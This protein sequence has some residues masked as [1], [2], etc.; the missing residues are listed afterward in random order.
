MGETPRSV[1]TSDSSPFGAPVGVTVGAPAAR[2]EAPSVATGAPVGVTVGAPA[3]RDE[4]PSVATG[5][6]S[7]PRSVS[8]VATWPPPRSR[9][10]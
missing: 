1:V 8:A 3:A 10:A 4:A 2:D 7:A 5:A 9:P 6:P